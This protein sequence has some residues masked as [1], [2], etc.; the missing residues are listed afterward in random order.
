MELKLGDGGSYCCPSIIP[1]PV[2]NHSIIKI[3]VR[4]LFWECASSLVFKFRISY[5]WLVD[6]YIYIYNLISTT[7]SFPK[8]WIPKTIHVPWI[9]TNN[10]DESWS[11]DLGPSLE[12]LKSR[13]L[14]SLSDR[15]AVRGVPWRCSVVQAEGSHDAKILW[16]CTTNLPSGYLT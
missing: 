1:N 15:A 5:R 3:P 10:L 2:I 14:R 4:W 8:V 16:G 9:I 13:R 11:H 12:R 7:W 6:L